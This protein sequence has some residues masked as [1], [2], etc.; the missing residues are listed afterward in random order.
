MTGLDL[1]NC[2]WPGGWLG[3][4]GTMRRWPPCGWGGIGTPRLLRRR[5]GELPNPRDI[6]A[7]ASV[8]NQANP[9]AITKGEGKNLPHFC[10]GSGGANPLTPPRSLGKLSLSFMEVKI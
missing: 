8:A 2:P 3:S 5:K 9:Q 10:C 4:L 7:D 6:L 1:R